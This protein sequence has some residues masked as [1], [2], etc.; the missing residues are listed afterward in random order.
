MWH[1]GRKLF[2]MECAN[3]A[4]RGAARMS[5]KKT[6]P[7]TGGVWFGGYETWPF[8]YRSPEVYIF[9]SLLVVLYFYVRD[10]RQRNQLVK[11]LAVLCREVETLEQLT[12]DTVRILK[13]S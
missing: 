2:T 12:A 5:S 8:I 11:P 10:F 7:R 6:L 9:C 1:I 13:P 4:L 3:M